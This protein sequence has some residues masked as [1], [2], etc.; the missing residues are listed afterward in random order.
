MGMIFEPQFDEH[1]TYVA[2]N[3]SKYVAIR[4]LDCDTFMLD[5]PEGDDSIDGMIFST[6]FETFEEA[7]R[8]AESRV[9]FKMDLV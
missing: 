7:V 4:K 8:W 3:S 6:M 9:S 1:N 2:A 5:L